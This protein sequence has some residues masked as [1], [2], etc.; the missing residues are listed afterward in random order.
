MNINVSEI[1]G[2]EYLKQ[3]HLHGQDVPVTIS[4][5]TVENIGDEDEE[6][7]Q[8]QRIVVTFAG[9]SKRLGLCKT[10]AQQIA[11]FYGD[12]A[13]GWIGQSITLWPDPSVT[14][15]GKVVGGVRIR[16]VPPE[17]A[18]QPTAAQ[19]TAPQPAPQPAAQPAAQP[20]PQPVLQP[21]PQPAVPPTPAGPVQF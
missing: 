14:Y 20:A 3:E 11:A 21:A 19:P 8:K 18:A 7:R 4:A 5:V 10:N 13:G 1:Y 9:Q 16:P 17:T 6:K 2:G 12:N 15:G